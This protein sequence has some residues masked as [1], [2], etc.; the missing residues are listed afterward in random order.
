MPVSIEYAIPFIIQHGSFLSEVFT[1]S[2][3]TKFLSPQVFFLEEFTN[4]VT[5]FLKLLIKYFYDSKGIE[6]LYFTFRQFSWSF[7]L[8][9]FKSLGKGN[10]FASLIK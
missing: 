1:S 10:P 7:S 8:G 3:P 6:L 5:S 4:H 9:Q 2:L